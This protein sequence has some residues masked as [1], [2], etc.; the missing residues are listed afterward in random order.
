MVLRLYGTIVIGDT[1]SKI[2]K[3]IVK[4]QH[5][6][7]K[8]YLRYFSKKV[9]KDYYIWVMDKNRDEPFNTNIENIA[10]S[11]YF[12]EVNSKP[13]NYWENYY[14]KNIESTLPK[15]FN[16]IIASATFSQNNSIILNN[17]VK[18]AMCKIILSQVSRT[19]KAKDFYDG[20]GKEITTT[21]IDEVYK[22]LDNILSKE[23][24]EI[25]EKYR[26]DEDFI[27]TMELDTINSD[28]IINKSTYYLM[29]RVWVV[30]KNLNYKKC[31]FIT[32]DHPVV[33]YNFLNSKSDLHSNGIG[34]DSTIIQYPIN[35][36]LLLVLYPRE[37]YFGELQKLNNKIVHI[38]DDDF[39]LKVDKLQYEQCYRQAYFTF[40]NE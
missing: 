1:M 11:K 23:H 5:Y 24:R 12:Y 30:Y 7:P 39:V 35:R 27:R 13:D 38:K 21:M 26:N 36:E 29:N 40:Y 31:P 2:K 18:I 33:Y 17:E 4:N 19:K 32:S 16:N 10:S 9:K 37:M 8:V 14:C 34:L 20:I 28:S 15:I 6:V 25:L 22:Q 3:K